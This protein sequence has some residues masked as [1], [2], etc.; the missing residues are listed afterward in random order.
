MRC[1]S[2][3]SISLFE[4]GIENKTSQ[5]FSLNNLFGF[6]TQLTNDVM[7]SVHSLI[8]LISK[9]SYCQGGPR[10]NGKQIEC[11]ALRIRL[12]LLYSVTSN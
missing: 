2:V 5:R 6:L 9:S 7:K 3:N 12:R 8:D 4:I 10:L 11:S 1:S